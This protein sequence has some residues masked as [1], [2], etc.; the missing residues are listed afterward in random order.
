MFCTISELHSESDVEQK[1]VMPFLR[2]GY[3][4]G[5]GFANVDIFTKVNLRHLSIDKGASAKVYRPDFILLINGIAVAVIEAKSPREDIL[6][7]LREARLYATELNALYPSSINPCVRIIACNG[8]KFV[9][10]PW[11]SDTPDCEV[12]LNDCIPSTQSFHNFLKLVSR[13]A[14]QAYSEKAVQQLRRQK[15]W[16]AQD[17]LGGLTARDEDVGYNSFGKDLAFEFEHIFNPTSTE[18]RANIVRNA[19]VPSKRRRHYVD[20]IDRIVHRAV[21]SLPGSGQL[22]DD[23]S[24]PA[25]LLRVLGRGKELQNKTLFLIGAV[26]SGKS[27]FIDFFREV[28]MTPE[29]GA[30]TV[31]VYI[32]V[33]ESAHAKAVFEK[34][35]AERIVARLRATEPIDLDDPDVVR[36]V[37]SVELQL[38]DKRVLSQLP[39]ESPRRAE[40]IAEEIRRLDADPQLHAKALARYLCG[41]RSKLLVIVMDNCDKGDAALQLT[42]FQIIKWLHSWLTCLVFL[43]LRDVTYDVYR[44][45]PPL[46]AIIKDHVFRIEP[47]PFTD[48]LRKR[49]A[50]ALDELRRA[51]KDEIHSYTL[52]GGATVVYPTSDLGVYLGCLYKSLF[53]HDALLRKMLVGLADRNLRRAIEIFIEFCKSGHISEAHILKIRLA[54]GEYALPYHVVTRVLLRMNRRFY[55]GS[56][57]IIRNLFQCNPLHVA[58]SNL[59]RYSILKWLEG[60]WGEFGP[61]KVKGFHR[62]ERMMKE[63]AP[64]GIDSSVL[65][66]D[67]KYLVEAGCIATE[68]QR[69]EIQSDSDLISLS[70]SGRA[71]LRMISN[72]DYLAACSE[73]C[74]IADEERVRQIAKR[75]GAGGRKQHYR[76]T[77]QAENA[78]ALAE[79][80]ATDPLMGSLTAKVLI[81]PF[82]DPAR[83]I[84]T[85]RDH[86][87]QSRD[88]VKEKFGWRDANRRFPAG[89]ECQ[90]FVD[91]ISARAVFVRL[92]NGPT[93]WLPT[94]GL[95]ND[96]NVNS[97]RKGQ[98]VNVR[99][100]SVNE[101]DEKMEL[102]YLGS[103]ASS[104]GH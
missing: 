18:Q 101:D 97:F 72:T 46:D 47:P 25:D 15:Y 63:L 8:H 9:T 87:F 40:L 91:G 98:V 45:S 61:T 96:I 86:I 29:I 74:W 10:A 100:V 6:E 30:R 37:Y 33:N 41:E 75:I 71:H 1:L 81:A 3:P 48:V 22:I 52:E 94:R 93:A 85:L 11:D 21:P 39:K 68:H 57:A 64:L 54:K 69:R 73:D 43:P 66:E 32:D 12:E 42:T 53:E 35:I 55:D 20:E 95:P 62:V 38:L 5:A 19:Y 83:D 16:R 78:A 23:T 31:W 99:V 14:L 103:I 92:E 89:M 70:A 58:P 77:T 84:N 82:L 67:V 27:T 2:A 102:E 60:M 88:R 17:L 4:N 51:G 65:E 7:G 50:L 76:Q 104:G 34:W 90:G 36:K 28:K 59:S 56:V 80:L 24:S 49:I 79:Y 44:N 13:A 26:G